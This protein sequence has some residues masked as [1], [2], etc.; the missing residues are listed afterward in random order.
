MLE[1]NKIYCTDA[2]EGLKQLD[3]NSIDCVMTSPPYWALRDYGSSV[4]TIWD[5]DKGCEHEWEIGKSSGNF[6]FRAGK[7]TIVGNNKNPEI[8]N[9]PSRKEFAN[10]SINLICPICK[11]E[12]EGKSNQKFCSIEC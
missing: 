7:T 5:E 12:F 10:Q 1:L 2:L 8:W 3:N 6:I 4:E 9:R 11:K